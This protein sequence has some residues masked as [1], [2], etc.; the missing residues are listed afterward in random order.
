LPSFEISGKKSF[1]RV[2]KPGRQ[3]EV[4]K[5]GEQQVQ[6]PGEQQVEKPGQQQVWKKGDSFANTCCK[7]SFV[8]RETSS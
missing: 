6:E 5:P 7:G 1:Q 3:Q 2:Q 4:Q 8:A